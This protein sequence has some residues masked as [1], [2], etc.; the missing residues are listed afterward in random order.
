MFA[1]AKTGSGES[2]LVTARSARVCT[3]VVAEAVSLAELGSAVELAPVAELVIVVA[4]GA[5]GFTCTTM[6]NTAVSPA[7]I[8]PFENTTLPFPPT[9]GELPAHPLPVVTDDETKVVLAGTVSVTVTDC[10]SLG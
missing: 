6:L 2:V 3:E 8:V 1:P 4:F 9:T 7:V 5:F 10:A